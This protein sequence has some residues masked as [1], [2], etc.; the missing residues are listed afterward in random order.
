MST[1]VE[2]ATGQQNPALEVRAVSQFYPGVRALD[3]VSFSIGKAEV[4]GL[5]G[6]N[7][8]GKSTLTRIIAGVER[9]ISGQV[10]LDGEPVTFSSPHDALMAGIAVVPQQLSL[11]PLMTVE[12][13]ITLGVTRGRAEMLRRALE[14]AK[15][16]GIDGVFHRRVGTCTPAAQRLVMIAR[17]LIRSP[18]VILLDEPTAAMHPSDVD[19]VFQAVE[20]VR[21]DGV[22]VVFISHRLEEILTLCSRIV[23]LRQGQIVA[24]QSTEGVSATLLGNLIAGRDL[25]GGG[26]TRQNTTAIPA[27]CEPSL[28]VQELTIAPVVSGV[29]LDVRP[30]E[31][32]GL[33]GLVG[34]GMTEVLESVAG[35]HPDHQGSIRVG[36]NGRNLKS[37]S[38][39]VKA[40]VAFI[41]DNR[42]Q[43]AIVP[44]LTVATTATLVNDRKY[45]LMPGLPLVSRQ[46]EHSAVDAVLAQLDVRPR[47]VLARPIRTLSGG[48]QQKVLIARAVLSEATVFAINEPTEGVD[49]A[50]KA[51]IHERI[52]GLAD[53]GGA[54]IVASS[55]PEELASLCDRILV[56]F[57]GRIVG[58]L[59]GRSMTKESITHACLVGS[60][61]TNDEA[62]ATTTGTSMRRPAQV[63]SSHNRS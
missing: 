2:P 31:I 17:A 27:S 61:R 52:R 1:P 30:G 11:V 22:A 35:L 36:S 54:V 47:D 57:D 39:S 60:V 5:V 34:A 14:V 4:V 10:I 26:S 40:G 9:P 24:D 56:M 58:E 42:S 49:V 45:R 15:L 46:R 37:R 44:G 38:A 59:S 8:A 43:N 23:V 12:D 16:L 63:S 19:R 55:E 25:A 62:R 29:S 18:S 41:P 53:S 3:D 7:G 51:D 13:N 28:S 32:V 48:N 20:R 50:A 6:H 21:A 33:A